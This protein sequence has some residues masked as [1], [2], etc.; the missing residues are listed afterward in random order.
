MSKKEI[1]DLPPPPDFSKTIA[2]LLDLNQPFPP[3]ELYQFS[4]LS[5]KDAGALEAAWT[6]IPVE[7]RRSLMQDLAEIAEAN[8]EVNF[9]AVFRLGLTDADVEVRAGAISGLWEEED[10]ELIAPFIEFL[11][12]DPDATVRAAAAT[13]LGRYVY[14]G[15]IAEVPEEYLRRIESALLAVF[16]TKKDVLDVRRRALEAIAYSNRDEVPRL[17]EAAYASSESKYRISAVF[18]MG[19]STD[20]RWTARVL[21]ELENGTPEMR[22]EAA[23]AAGELELS[24]A[25]PNLSKLAEDGDQQVREAAIWSLGQ[26][27]GPEARA[28][29]QKLLAAAAEDDKEFIEDAVENLVFNEGLQDFALLALDEDDEA[30]K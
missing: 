14:L 19:R 21:A 12:T 22:F 5:P 27:G 23:R 26:I 10:P 17:I 15:E 9:A 6:E 3:K 25:V 11:N 16:T 18:A 8:Y 2:L 28:A 20:K 13:A 30:D 24:E 4:D 29:L 7:R 1:P